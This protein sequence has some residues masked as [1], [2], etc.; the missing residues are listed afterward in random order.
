MKG[1]RIL[2]FM[3]KEDSLHFNSDQKFDNIKVKDV[4]GG[5]SD[6]VSHR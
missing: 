6:G 3:M 2:R 5:D 1:E 4:I